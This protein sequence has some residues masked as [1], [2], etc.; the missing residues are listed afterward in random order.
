MMENQKNK[1]W[2]GILDDLGDRLFPVRQFYYRSQGNVRFISLNK[3]AQ[4][5]LTTFLVAA[6]GWV[7]FASSVSSI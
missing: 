1:D 6:F 5:I 2:R 4:G 7:V 3:S